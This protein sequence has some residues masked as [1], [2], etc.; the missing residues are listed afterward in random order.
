MSQ[1]K[2][3]SWSRKPEEPKNPK[4]AAEKQLPRESLKIN[5]Q[6][7]LCRRVRVYQGRH[8]SQGRL[9]R[10]KG[11]VHLGGPG[12]VLGIPTQSISQRAEDQSSSMYKLPVEVH[13]PQEPLQDSKAG[14]LAGGKKVVMAERCL[15]RGADPELETKFP[16]YST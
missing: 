12:E 9:G 14:Q 2:R 4:L 6:R 8:Q 10:D 15:W 16:R 1:R 13:H 5:S 3:A 11:R 7:N